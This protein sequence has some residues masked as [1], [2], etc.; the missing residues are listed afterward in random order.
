VIETTRPAAIILI[1]MSRVEIALDV[2]GRTPM[3]KA[4]TMSRNTSPPPE[5]IEVNS[6]TVACDGDGGALGHP[7]VFINLRKD[8]TGECGYC[9]RK[10][11]LRAEAK[12][13]G[14]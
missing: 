1:G 5:T 13:G 6:T 10:F 2:T 9:D 3:A 8:G 4:S 11:V 12:A 14:H 7:R